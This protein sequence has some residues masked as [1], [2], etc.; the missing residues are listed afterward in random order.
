M[1]VKVAGHIPAEA[2][3]SGL[4]QAFPALRVVDFKVL[5]EGPRSTV[6]RFRIAA[7]DN[8]GLYGK[9]S[10]S[11]RRVGVGACWHAHRA[12][13]V[14]LFQHIDPD[15]VISTALAKYEGWDDFRRKYLGTRDRDPST[16]DCHGFP[17]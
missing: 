11:G 9:R 15:A 12:F 2:L 10:A 8:R 6:V 16:C 13:M 7:T 5:R 14:W 4:E 1:Q 17:L 3:K